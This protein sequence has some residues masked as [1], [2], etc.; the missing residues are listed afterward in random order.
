MREGRGA[1]AVGATCALQA[2]TSGAP[3]RGAAP[4]FAVARRVRIRDMS[5]TSVSAGS[6]ASGRMAATL[7][8]SDTVSRQKPK[9][10]DDQEKEAW[11]AIK[12]LR[13]HGTG[14]AASDDASRRS[15]GC[16]AWL[17]TLCGNKAK[18][19][20]SSFTSTFR[21]RGKSRAF[22]LAKIVGPDGMI[23]ARTDPILPGTD[24]RPTAT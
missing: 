24:T 19:P 20:S 4:A 9:V 23:S 3:A 16:M 15:V 6:G 10:V 8:H 2:K 11:K 1:R 7:R 14:A 5:R 22:T 12:Q 17:P 21:E 13:K 18:S